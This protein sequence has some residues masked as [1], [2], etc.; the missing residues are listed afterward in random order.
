MRRSSN[1]NAHIVLQ[2]V[3]V[4]CSV[5]QCVAVCCSV[6]QCVA[7]CC[8]V[9]QW[10][11]APAFSPPPIPLIKPS[12]ISD[13]TKAKQDA[14]NF[15]NVIKDACIHAAPVFDIPTPSSQ[16]AYTSF[17]HQTHHSSSIADT[18]SDI[19]ASPSFPPTSVNPPLSSLS[20]SSSPYSS[21]SFRRRLSLT[22][23]R[24]KIR[25]MSSNVK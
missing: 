24:R 11:G 2:C 17:T 18:S 22:R 21:S 3:A 19:A 6:L 8:S 23:L 16:S 7:V 25:N 15:W 5:L 12:Q 9:L 4:C 14:L 1:R 10:S 13:S 20:S